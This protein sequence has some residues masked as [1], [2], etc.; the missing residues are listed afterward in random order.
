[1]KE[2]IRKSGLKVIGDLP[3]GIHICQFYRNKRDLVDILVPFFKAG[4][5]N[6]EF[7]LWIT[8]EPLK[9]E[10]ALTALKKKVKNLDKFIAKKQIEILD[11]SQWYAQ[12]G[13]FEA[14]KVLTG[15]VRKEKQALQNG[16]DG[17]RASGNTFWLESSDWEEFS[18]YERE[19]NNVISSYKMLAICSYHLDKC[20]PSEAVDVVSYHQYALIKKK[21]W[22]KLVENTEYIKK[23]RALS[24]ANSRLQL[25]QQVT[26]AIHGTLDLKKVFKNISF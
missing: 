5:E 7:C 17:L 2:G 21:G 4:L 20:G 3:W 18:D 15:W 6:N 19:V 1:V 26:D 11:S 13:K 24:E 9:Q 14:E 16:F 22:W 10:E 8:S 25:L 23:E 12:S